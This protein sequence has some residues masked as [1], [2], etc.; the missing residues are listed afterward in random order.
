MDK[1]E[2]K[3]SSIEKAVLDS[4]FSTRQPVFQDMTHTVEEKKTTQ[5]IQD[6]LLP[7]LQISDE[8]IVDYMLQS[9]YLLVQDDDGSPIWQMWRMR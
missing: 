9:G 2:Y 1:K 8:V 5:Q 3:A 7:T 6:D 4:Y